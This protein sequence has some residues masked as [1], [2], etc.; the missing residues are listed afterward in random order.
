ML[1]YKT[2]KLP[3]N[4]VIL[5]ALLM[6]LGIWRMILT[7]W[8]G[9]LFFLTGLL[10]FFIRSGVMIDTGEKQLKQYTGFPGI[11]NGKWENIKSL[12]GLKITASRETRR[13]NVLSIGRT[14]T[15][16]VYRLFMIFPG[17]ETEIMSGERDVILK[18]AEQIASALEVPLENGGM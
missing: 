12:E 10:L 17:R 18:R 4:F 14:S 16:T 5:G 11:T 8:P 1:H 3:P 7:D 6:A 2:E 13:M 15:E 9:I